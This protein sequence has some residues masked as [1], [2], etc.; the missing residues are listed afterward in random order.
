M[1]VYLDA[2]LQGHAVHKL[3]NTHHARFQQPSLAR[4]GGGIEHCSSMVRP[5]ASLCLSVCLDTDDSH[6]HAVLKEGRLC[7]RDSIVGVEGDVGIFQQLP[8]RARLGRDITCPA[9]GD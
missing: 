5:L 8:H 7:R 9:V 6:L 1:A 3:L 2:I 4:G